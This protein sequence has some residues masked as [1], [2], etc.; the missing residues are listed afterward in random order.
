MISH[1][2]QVLLAGPV[3]KMRKELA[4]QSKREVALTRLNRDQPADGS[5][6]ALMSRL[7]DMP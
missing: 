1:V 5:R 6:T 7:G 4:L 3:N 2:R